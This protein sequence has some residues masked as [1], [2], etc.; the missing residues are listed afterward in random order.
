MMN[1]RHRENP[2][3][4]QLKTENL[5]NDRH[6][7]DHKDPTDDGKQELLLAANRHDPNHSADRERAGVA[8][9]HPC[10]MTIEPKKSETRADQRAAND[11]ELTRKRVKGNT[12]IFRNPEIPSRV[13]EKRVCESDRDR[14]AG[15]ETIEAI[16]QIHSVGRAHD[17]EG[18]K[19]ER[20]PT[21]VRDDR[22]LNE[23]HVKRTR[24]HF[25][26]WTG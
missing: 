7:L 4:G 13:G 1:R 9:K 26:Q 11:R 17:N 21:H 23:R 25:E 24:L 18:E 10:R 5:Q 6:G 19:Q 20:K 2:T 3:T 15:G 8:H 22:R 12:Q 14:A 16:G